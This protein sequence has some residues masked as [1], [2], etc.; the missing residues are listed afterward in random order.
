MVYLIVVSLI[1]AFSFGIIKGSLAGM[2]PYTVTTIRLFFSLIVFLPFTRFK[3]F[4]TSKLLHALGIGIL[5][6]GLMY[7]FYIKSFQYLKAYEIA[8]FTIFTPIYISLF[9]ILLGDK[10]SY[11]FL[12]VAILSFL[13]GL[14]IGYKNLTS[15]D[16]ITGFILVQLS[17]I[18][19]AA[20]QILYKKYFGEKNGKEMFGILYLGAF[21]VTFVV[22]IYLGDFRT[23]EISGSQFLSL[24][25]LGV[26]ASGVSFFLW[27]KGVTMV[28]IGTLSVM[29]NLKVPLGVIASIMILNESPDYF[30]LVIGSAIMIFGLYLSLKSN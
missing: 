13:G 19:F 11:K 3:Y 14:I 2:D 15:S 5:Q 23:T 12:L 26:I 8:M 20:G 25:Y 7:I 24:F 10:F 27:N 9:Q 18:C 1:W 29:N 22:S 4:D 28:N 21:L 6:F 30:Y 16:F 17:N